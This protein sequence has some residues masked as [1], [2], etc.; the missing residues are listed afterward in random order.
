MSS[1]GHLDRIHIKKAEKILSLT[2]KVFHD[3]HSNRKEAIL[4]KR[5]QKKSPSINCY[6]VTP[7][8]LSLIKIVSIE[9]SKMMLKVSRKLTQS[10]LIGLVFI[11]VVSTIGCASQ[12]TTIAPMPSKKYERLGHVSGSATGHLGILTPPLYF[13]PMGLHSRMERAYNDALK[14]APGA[15]GL[16]DVTYQESWFWWF[17]ATGRTVTISGEAIKEVK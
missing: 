6:N 9:R 16:I 2:F 1:T 17:I 7:C 3:N 5:K 11:F 15:T 4:N 12:F 10:A 14:K 13:I 8:H